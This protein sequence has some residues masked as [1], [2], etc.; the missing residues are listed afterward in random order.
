MQTQVTN[1]R[2]RTGT[3]SEKHRIANET[4]AMQTQVYRR[5]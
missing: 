4:S 1:L 3:Q 2:Y 5:M